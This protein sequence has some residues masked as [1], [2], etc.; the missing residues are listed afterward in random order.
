MSQLNRED[1]KN[2]TTDEIVHAKRG[3]RLDVL[4][5]RAVAS[6]QVLDSIERTAGDSDAT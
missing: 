4:L 5:G 2:M 3:G 1:L 6:G